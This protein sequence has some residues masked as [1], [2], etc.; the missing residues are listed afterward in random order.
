MK[1]TYVEPVKPQSTYTIVM[2]EDDYRT[3]ND[4]TYYTVT[5]PDA[6]AGQT[7]DRDEVERISKFLCEFNRADVAKVKL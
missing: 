5:I 4:I 7:K 1:I 6:I 2:N 3:L